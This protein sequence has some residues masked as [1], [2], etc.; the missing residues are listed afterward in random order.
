M[1]GSVFHSE[2]AAGGDDGVEE[3]VGFDGFG[4]FAGVDEDGTLALLTPEKDMPAG[5]VIS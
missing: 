5:A 1:A 3:S 4:Q 2:Q